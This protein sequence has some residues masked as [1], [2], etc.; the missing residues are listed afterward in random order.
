MKNLLRTISFGV[1][2]VIVTVLAAAT[3]LE[4]LCGSPFAVEN[5]HHSWWFIAL[6]ALL[7]VTATSYIL[8]T[9]RRG[10][11]ILLH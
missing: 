7:A 4:K 6:W 9:Q 8:R 2:A 5:I 3:I 11:L 10:S 1:A